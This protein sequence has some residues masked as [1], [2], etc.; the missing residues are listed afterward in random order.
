MDLQ[1][2]LCFNGNCQEA[3]DFYAKALN[4]RA[5]FITTYAMYKTAYP[6][7]P[8][9]WDDKIMHATF[10]ADM[11]T[12]MLADMPSKS[13]ANTAS[14]AISLCLNF[15][16]TQ[17]QAQVF[18][19]LSVD[20]IITMQLQDTFWGA[21]FGTITDKFGVKWMLNYDNRIHDK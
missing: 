16:N 9:G 20:G 4:G 18:N 1:P 15:T 10:K 19:A 17:T 3:L 5:E 14:L 6:D 12:F 21:T 13:N 2:Y 7:I 11:V 8:V